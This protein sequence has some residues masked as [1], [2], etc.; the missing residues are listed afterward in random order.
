MNTNQITTVRSM[1]KEQL[2]R[3]IWDVTQN[4]IKTDKIIY[5]IEEVGKAIS[6]IINQ[7]GEQKTD[8]QCLDEVIEYLRNN[9]LYTEKSQQPAVEKQWEI[10]TVASTNSNWIWVKEAE[11]KWVCTHMRSGSLGELGVKQ[12]LE[13]GNLSIHSVQIGT[14]VYTVS[15]KVCWNWSSMCGQESEIIKGLREQGGELTLKVESHDTHHN[16]QMMID[17]P[18]EWKFRHYT[19]PVQ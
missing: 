10:V 2:R 11:N 19:E 12:G 15:D 9:N 16:L 17:D 13:T 18:K 6:K 7:D 8:G 5:L 14:E 4:H 1:E 3:R